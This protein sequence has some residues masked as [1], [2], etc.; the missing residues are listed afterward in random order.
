[1][2]EYGRSERRHSSFYIGLYGQT[3]VSFKDTCMELVA[4]L[5]SLNRSKLE[6]YQRGLRAMKV[7]ESAF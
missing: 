2:R 3:W 4:E 7:I 6:Y 5:M 1:M